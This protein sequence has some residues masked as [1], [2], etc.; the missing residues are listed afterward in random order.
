MTFNKLV[1]KLTKLEG[2]KSSVNIGDMRETLS[3]LKKLLKDDD[4]AFEYFIVKYLG[5]KLEDE[6]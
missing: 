4:E 1:S 3:R 2:G 6:E 5:L